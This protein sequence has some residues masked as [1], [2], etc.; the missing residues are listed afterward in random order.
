[1]T[2][3]ERFDLLSNEKID[4]NVYEYLRSF[5]NDLKIEILGKHEGKLFDLMKRGLLEGGAG[6]QQRQLRYLC[7]MM[8]WFIEEIYILINMILIIMD[9]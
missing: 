1:M 6:K 8:I 5:F 9:L 3:E 7:L 2:K 4:K